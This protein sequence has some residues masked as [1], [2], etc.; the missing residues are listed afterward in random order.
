M[1]LGDLEWSTAAA[2]MPGELESGDSYLACSTPDGLLFAVIDGVG[3]GR[4]AAAA[5]TL[6][7]V[8][9]QQYACGTVVNLLQRCH[10]ALRATR[11]V[12][13]SLAA[14]AIRPATLT[15]IGVGNVEDVLLRGDVSA[16]NE[17]LLVRSGLVGAHLPVLQ[18]AVTAVEPGDTL[19]MATDGLA[20][21]FT[22]YVAMQ[23]CSEATAQRILARAS[24]GTDDALV[25][26]A[27]YRRGEP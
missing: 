26:V 18:A 13:M 14:F 9:L 20:G 22:E 23:D 19:I 11:G 27:R 6:A 10:E 3:H 16:R 7:R 21:D 2:T 25:L 5:A 24:K 8:T 1:N 15:W 17:R 4:E 12:T